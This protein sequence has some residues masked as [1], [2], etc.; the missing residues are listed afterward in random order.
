MLMLRYNMTDA[1]AFAYL[2]RRSQTENIKVREVAQHVAAELIKHP[3]PEEPG[4][5][6]QAPG[7]DESH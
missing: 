2:S 7:G 4:P 6:P 5:S 1:H 3:W